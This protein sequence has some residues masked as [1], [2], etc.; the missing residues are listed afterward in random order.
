MDSKPMRIRT[1]QLNSLKIPYQRPLI[2]AESEEF[3]RED[4][5][6][7]IDETWVEQI[8]LEEPKSAQLPRNNTV[9]SKFTLIL[10]KIS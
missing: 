5:K 10:C 4:E 7:V 2:V 3:N 6:V 9:L 1:T 8:Y